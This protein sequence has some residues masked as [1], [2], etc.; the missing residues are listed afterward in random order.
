ID[1][2]DIATGG[3]A[4][5]S[6]LTP[7]PGGGASGNLTF[8]IANP[9]PSV[10]SVSPSSV[11]AGALAFTVTVTGNGFA[12]AS[13]VRWNGAT[14]PTRSVSARRWEASIAAADVATAGTAQVSVVT[15]SPGGGTSGDL[16]F[17]IANPVPGVLSLSPSSV[18]AGAPAFTVTVNGS[19]FANASV[20]RWN[21]ATR[22]TTF[23]KIG[24][25]HV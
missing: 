11:T 15:P 3:T 23:V 9:V 22:P 6:V 20:V 8:T 12:N 10:V 17:T 2:A 18:T 21:G 1:A 13:V 14:R 16:T 24:R 19:G 5:V 4:Q 25:A 7:A